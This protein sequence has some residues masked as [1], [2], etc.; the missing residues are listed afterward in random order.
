MQESSCSTRSYQH[1]RYVLIGCIAVAAALWPSVLSAERAQVA[2]SSVFIVKPNNN[3]NGNTLMQGKTSD[4][5]R[6]VAFVQQA[7][8]SDHT[9]AL[10][11]T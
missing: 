4:P 3:D 2:A 10:T 8:R 9:Y 5:V 6:Q 11:K 1:I 7:K